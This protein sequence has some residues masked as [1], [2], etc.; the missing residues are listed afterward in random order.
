[1]FY[2]M[3]TSSCDLFKMCDECFVFADLGYTVG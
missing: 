1:M 2:S 3:K